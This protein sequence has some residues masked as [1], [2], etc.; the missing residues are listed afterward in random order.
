MS[1][2]KIIDVLGDAEAKVKDLGTMFSDL[3]AQANKLAEDGWEVVGTGPTRNALLKRNF[4]VEL[5]RK[6]PVVAIVI[7]WFFPQLIT[8]HVSLILKK[9]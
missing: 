7:N 2:I 8:T 9:D 1:Q 4:I 5:L 3:E 6:I